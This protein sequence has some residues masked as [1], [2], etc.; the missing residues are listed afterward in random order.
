M[1]DDLNTQ[2]EPE[3]FDGLTLTFNNLGLGAP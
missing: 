2:E 1:E 3:G